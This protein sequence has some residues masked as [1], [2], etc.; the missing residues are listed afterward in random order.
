MSSTRRVAIVTG[1]SR[2]IGRAIALR[3]AQDGFNVVINY[4][5]NVAKAQELIDE[6]AAL[7]VASNQEP[8]SAIAVQGDIGHLEQGQRL[9]DA[10]IAAY[11][12]LDIVVLNAGWLVYQ[13]IHHMTEASYTE[14]FNTNVKGPMFFSKIAQPYLVQAQDETHALMTGGSPQGGS[15]IITISTSLTTLSMVQGDHMVYSATKGALEQVT[16][17]LAK[18]KEFGGRGITVNTIAP[19]PVDTESFRRGLDE[20]HVSFFASLHPQ[21]RLGATDDIA[22]VVSFLASD[23]SKWVNGQTIRANGGMGRN[24]E[25]RQALAKALVQLV[26]ELLYV[27]NEA[28]RCAQQALACYFAEEHHLIEVL[29]A[30]RDNIGTFGEKAQDAFRHLSDHPGDLIYRHFFSK[31]LKYIDNT[32]LIA[33]DDDCEAV[34]NIP[35]LHLEG[36]DKETYEGFVEVLEDEDQH[37]KARDAFK[38]FVMEHLQ[39][40]AYGLTKEKPPSTPMPNA[41]RAKLADARELFASE[42]LVEELLPG[43]HY[44]I[45]SIDP[46]ICNTATATVLD[47]RTPRQIKNVSV[48]QGSHGHAIKTFM[49]GPNKAKKRVTI[50]IQ[51]SGEDHPSAKSILELEQSISSI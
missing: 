30:N 36:E 23:D 14:A 41:T 51:F 43:E 34:A 25:E 17:T 45:V 12:R 6:I 9:L 1:S 8:V 35:L 22:G 29:Y 26:Q 21:N 49:E 37:L 27:G 48:S 7:P 50:D 10:T 44:V 32:V 39:I 4:Q 2:G 5:S 3:L 28:M 18:D 19:G 47:T 13:S 42:E 33:P 11:G 38:Q 20:A 16:R 46:G 31:R 40:L 24:E 15:R